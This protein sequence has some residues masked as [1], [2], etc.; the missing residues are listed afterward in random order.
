MIKLFSATSRVDGFLGFDSWVFFWFCVGRKKPV[1]PYDK[2][3]TNYDKLDAAQKGMAELFID[4]HFTEAE[5][6]ELREYLY[7]VYGFQPETE[8]EHLPIIFGNIDKQSSVLPPR[9]AGS[10]SLYKE[11]GYNLTIPVVAEYCLDD[12]PSDKEQSSIQ[13]ECG[14]KFGGYLLN[15]LNL[16]LMK[17][18]W[19]S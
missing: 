18:K 13:R 11:E 3:I 6:K 1:V 15:G 12:L 19:I 5:V 7:R 16:R 10:Y 17:S 14:E 4:A 2:A 9:S 8:E